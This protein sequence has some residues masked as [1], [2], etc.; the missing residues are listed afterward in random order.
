MFELREPIEY[1]FELNSSTIS[2][3]LHCQCDSME[4]LRNFRPRMGR[5]VMRGRFLR[6][7][8]VVNK[9]LVRTA[10]R[11]EELGADADLFLLSCN[12]TQDNFHFDTIVGSVYYWNPN[13][14]KFIY[15]WNIIL[16]VEIERNWF[17]KSPSDCR[18]AASA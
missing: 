9:G 16:N 3:L 8:L 17:T 2:D 11:L 13:L 14:S 5:I 10:L 7:S 12:I 1:H 15:K 18:Y 6:E 4:Y